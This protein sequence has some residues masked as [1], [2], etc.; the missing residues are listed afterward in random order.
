MSSSDVEYLTRRH[1]G[2]IAEVEKHYWRNFILITLDSSFY[3]FA[4]VTLSQDTIL[5]YFISQFS[6]NPL[7]IGLVPALYW[8]GF[9]FP[10]LIGAFLASGKPRRK[11][12]IFW[13]AVTQ[14]M[15]ILLIAITTQYLLKLPHNLAL[16]FF[17]LSYFLFTVMNG[18]IGPAYADF[19]SKAII[20][21]RGLFFGAMY[22]L[23]GLIGF[24]AS[25]L[26]RFLLNTRT[27]PSNLQ[28]LFW[29]GFATSF[30]SPIIIANFREVALP[31]TVP[32][33]PFSAFLKS[34]PVCIRQYPAF[35]RYILARLLLGLGFMGNSFYAVYAIQ[36]FDLASGSLGIFTMII[37]LS[38]SGLGFLW[39]WIGDRFGYKK[40]LLISAILILLEGVIAL[41]APSALF[42]FFIALLVGGVYSAV[43][44]SDQNLVYEIAPP[45]ETSRFVGIANTLLAPSYLL[46]PLFGGL[47]VGKVSHN[48][49]F[50][51]V[52]GLALVAIF[53]V[54]RWVEEPR[55]KKESI[56]YIERMRK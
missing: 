34:V 43:S 21:R 35:G 50:G 55:K 48:A 36:R 14:R 2:Y 3:S 31:D 5:P 13:I 30:I 10:Q 1:P 33:G 39:G 53:A 26:A 51:V 37:L 11:S 4:A 42:F 23:S 19:I 27:F 49:L 8:F 40:V 22:G 25:Y 47:L 32:V 45:H 20:R 12:L 54:W 17:F 44:I 29:L 9:Y 46:A 41:I 24:S 52:S 16:A 28:V 7:L 18:M 38:Q 15:G 56:S 6:G